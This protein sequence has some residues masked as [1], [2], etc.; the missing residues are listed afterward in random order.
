MLRAT[1]IS[2]IASPVSHALSRCFRIRSV[3]SNLRDR[4]FHVHLTT[5]LA[6]TGGDRNLLHQP[7]ND[8]GHGGE[9]DSS[10]SDADARIRKSQALRRIEEF[11]TAVLALRI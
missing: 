6:E 7:Q 4:L 10:A 11:L 8:Y 9:Q 2:A 3:R 5:G 1:R